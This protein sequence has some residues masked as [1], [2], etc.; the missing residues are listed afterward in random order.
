L[1]EKKLE[2][3]FHTKANVCSHQTLHTVDLIQILARHQWQVTK[4]LHA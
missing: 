3:D 2:S 1:N 4:L